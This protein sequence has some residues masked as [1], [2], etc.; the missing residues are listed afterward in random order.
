MAYH[1]TGEY[2]DWWDGLRF[3]K[4]IRAWAASV[5]A[6]VT[7]DGVQRILLGEPSDSTALGTGMIPHSRIIET[8][9]RANV[10]NAIASVVVKHKSGGNSSL[11]FKSYDQ[12]REK[13]QADTLDLIWLDEEPS[14]DIYYES[15][16]RTNATKGKVYMTFTPL[17]GM[18][19]IVMRFLQEESEDMNV[20][21]MTIEDAEHIDEEERERIIAGYPAHE[22]EARVKG[23]PALGSGRVF[24]IAEEEIRYTSTPEQEAFLDSLPAIGGLDFGWDHPTAC[25]EVRHDRDADCVYVRRTHRQREATPVLIA[26]SV[27]PWGD[28]IPW[29]WPHDGLQHDKGS[30][31]RLADL[32][33]QQGLNMCEE[34][35]QFE[36]GGNGVEAG[37]MEML[38]RMQTGRLK[39][40][41]HLEDWWQEF[42]LYHRKDGVVVKERDDLMAATRYAIM[43]L[44]EATTP[45]SRT[46]PVNRIRR[47]S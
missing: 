27:K 38:D 26:A 10:P 7:R 21:R 15:L 45:P 33:E 24:P 2:P 5:T 11:V 43:M 23:I 3:D 30:G 12:G 40:A 16:T 31:D 19:D 14:A 28:W 37:L 17:K 8:K 29:A 44:R 18:S 20:T 32:Y 4:P 41:E 22:R 42:R 39:V 47:V 25:V 9:R 46:R 13:F 36:D 1:L 35:A 34:R 6:E